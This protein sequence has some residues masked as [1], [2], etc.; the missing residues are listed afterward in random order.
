MEGVD[1]EPGFEAIPAEMPQ[2]IIAAIAKN[3]VILDLFIIKNF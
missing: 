1:G 3:L 2:T